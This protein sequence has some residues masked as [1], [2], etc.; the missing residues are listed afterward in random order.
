MPFMFSV[1]V[2]VEVVSC[3]YISED[4]M[5]FELLVV[6]ILF[7]VLFTVKDGRTQ[8]KFYTDQNQ[9]KGRSAQTS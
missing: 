3:V 9:T 2:T 7:K 4:C 5:H 1:Y 6:L 8:Y